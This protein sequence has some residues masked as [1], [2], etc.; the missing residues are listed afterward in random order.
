MRVRRWCRTNREPETATAYGRST[1]VW[2][3]APFIDPLI[4][5]MPKMPE[6]SPED[7]ARVDRITSTGVYGKERKPFRFWSLMAIL[8]GVLLVLTWISW[9]I[10]SYFEYV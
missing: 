6:L 10:A 7:Q 8:I 1:A 9:A 2:P 4:E 5:K 3:C